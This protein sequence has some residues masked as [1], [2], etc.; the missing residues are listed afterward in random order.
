MYTAKNYEQAMSVLADRRRQAEARADAL[1]EKLVHNCPELNTVDYRIRLA[2]SQIATAA[3]S[4][5]GVE[6]V[7]NLKH[8]IQLLQVQKA[9]LLKPLGFVPDDLL[10][11][12]HCSLC[13]DTGY[14]S[15]RR[16]SCLEHLLA[17]SKAS[18]LPETARD[19][20]Y[21]FSSFDLSY[22][23]ALPDSDGVSPR[24]RM[25]AI[26][27]RCTDYAGHFSLQS[28]NLLFLGSTGLGKTHLSLAIAT[29]VLNR[30]FTVQYAPIQTLIS[31]LERIQFN[32]SPSPEDQELSSL[33]QCCDLLILDDL[34]SEFSSPFAASALYNL[35]NSRMIE[36]RPLVISSNLE[37]EKL[38]T[39]YHDRIVSRLL[40]NCTVLEFRGR[41]IRLEKRKRAVVT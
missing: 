5:D 41:D 4:P 32:R 18:G 24:S 39:T 1:R 27:S 36:S 23:S 37:L 30:G 25:T 28:G 22:Y 9:D 31:A 35:L 29:E 40:C 6:R 3:M 10:P 20:A 11:Q 26:L 16:C 19:G 12:Y 34:G 14:V 2:A 38:Y 33:S 17:S 7:E 21:H 8:Q 15:S 13:G